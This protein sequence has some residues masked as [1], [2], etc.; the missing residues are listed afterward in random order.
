MS[1]FLLSNCCWLLLLLVDCLTSQQQASVSQGRICSDNCTCCHTE[2]EVADQTFYL[3][4]SQYTDTGPT[5]PSADPITP[6][7]WQGSHWSAN[8]SSHWYDST[9]KK[10]RRKRDSN[11][12]P[13]ALEADALT[14][15]PTR[16]FVVGD[17]ELHYHSIIPSVY[18]MCL[19]SI[20]P[21][22]EIGEMTLLGNRVQYGQGWQRTEKFGGLWRRA[23]SCSG[24]TQPTIKKNRIVTC[25]PTCLLHNQPREV[26]W[27]QPSYKRSAL[28]PAFLPR[29]VLTPA[30]L[31]REVLTP[32]FLPREVL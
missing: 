5:S 12:G 30:F 10:S 19:N 32:A 27:L 3:T 28:T 6:G 15:R 29:E 21:Q 23:T 13:S 16:R 24:R 31:P 22:R 9:P 25:P 1:K 2:I 4:Q 20:H 17:C 11:P 18:L 8:F 26:L 7:A 14:T